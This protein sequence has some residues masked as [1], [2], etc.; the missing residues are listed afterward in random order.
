MKRY[1]WYI[2]VLDRF[3]LTRG[4]IIDSTEDFHSDDILRAQKIAGMMGMEQ[5]VITS[6]KRLEEI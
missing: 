1:K 2:I 6:F 3:G 4:M 5:V